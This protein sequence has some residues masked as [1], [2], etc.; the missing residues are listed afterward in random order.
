MTKL[1]KIDTKAKD[2]AEKLVVS[3]KFANK[4]KEVRERNNLPKDGFD[5]LLFDELVVADIRPRIPEEVNMEKYT[6]SVN[7]VLWL[8]GFSQEWFDFFSDYILFNYVGETEDKKQIF[9]LDLGYRNIGKRDEH[10]AILEK[11][12]IQNPITI[13]LP[14]YISQRDIYDF[15]SINWEKI[16]KIQG[17]YQKRLIKI[18]SSRRKNERVKKRD[19]F[20]YKNRFL[21][22]KEL[23]SKIAD[24]FGDVM[25]YTYLS[26]IIANEEKKRSASK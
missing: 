5:I 18:V 21:P 20:I 26:K 15:I 17:K 10:M 25:D 7:H 11:N 8:Y 14:P 4:V 3:P 9:L 22:K 12:T 19:A 2:Y 16:E 1:S 23:M 6:K 24:E 13:L